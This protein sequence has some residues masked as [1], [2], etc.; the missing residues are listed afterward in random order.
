MQGA[1][2]ATVVDLLQEVKER[3][4][5]DIVPSAHLATKGECLQETAKASQVTNMLRASPQGDPSEKHEI[6][7]KPPKNWARMCRQTVWC[8]EARE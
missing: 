5:K 1:I 3:Y 2:E 7:G 4:S 6:Y 8:N